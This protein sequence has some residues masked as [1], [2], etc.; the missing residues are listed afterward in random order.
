MVEYLT[1]NCGALGSVFPLKKRRGVRGRGGEKERR[2]RRKRQRGNVESIAN[3]P[4]KQLQIFCYFSI[5]PPP[6]LNTHV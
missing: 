3:S 1:G 5:L 4:R 2:R 6:T